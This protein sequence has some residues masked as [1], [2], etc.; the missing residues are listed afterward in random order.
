[1]AGLWGARSA[2]C[3]ATDGENML[4]M[5]E[6]EPRLERPVGTPPGLETPAASVS[7]FRRFWGGAKADGARGRKA[8]L[9]GSR[10]S[11]G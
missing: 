11:R 6:R 9:N 8:L 7:I 2:A 1:L 3:E 10:C 5:L 4:D